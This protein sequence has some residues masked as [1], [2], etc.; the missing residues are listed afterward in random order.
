M[1]VDNTSKQQK[2]DNSENIQLQQ[3]D[4]NL[5]SAVNA[6]FSTILSE[7][8]S[9]N[10]IILENGIQ[11]PAIDFNY[12]SISMNIEDAMF[13]VNLAQ[14]G[15]FS[16]EN[17]Q[18][19]DFK[20]IIQTEIAQNTIS[21]KV[22]E[23][24]NQITSLIEKAQNTQKPVRISFDNDVS[25]V[26]KIDKH[27]KVSAEFIP[28]SLEVENYLRNNISALRQRFDEQNLPYNELYYRQQNN[29]QNRN[30]KKGEQ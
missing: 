26:L 7:K 18:N 25:V 8:M 15:K 6:E 29:R 1:K 23:V 3:E 13:F 24:T 21:R 27:G 22:V 10:N 2:I 5:L 19:G 11:L 20:A 12:D 9:D 16:V 30:K 28:G 14:D 17:A 4:N